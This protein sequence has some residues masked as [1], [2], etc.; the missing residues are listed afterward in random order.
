MLAMA[1][2]SR[3]PRAAQV[4]E[5]AATARPTSA[6]PEFYQPE[7]WRPE[8][9]MGYL[10]K[11]IIATVADAV[12]HELAPTGLTSAQWIP[13]LKLYLGEASTVAE[14]ARH[15]TLD[16]GA[17]TRTLDRLEAK[18]LVRRVRSSDDRRV[19][20]LELT[21]EGRATAKTIPAAL[22]RVQNAHLRGF[23]E[24]EWTLLKGMLRRI[25]DT[26]LELQKEREEEGNSQQ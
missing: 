12:D 17:M 4:V 1:N 24:S 3:T 9:S 19:V 21:D 6:P 2:I 23:T 5:P 25:L 8:Q 10:M 15:C 18:E 16:A 13:L 26:A 20:N 22:C 11:R 14:L 7:T